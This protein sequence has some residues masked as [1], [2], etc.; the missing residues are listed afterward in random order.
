MSVALLA[1][2]N[3][4]WLVYYLAEDMALSFLYKSLR[5]DFIYAVFFKFICV[6]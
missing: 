5:R 4:H 3:A 6:P 2:T 1:V